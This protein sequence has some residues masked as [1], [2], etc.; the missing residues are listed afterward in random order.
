M[1]TL[2]KDIFKADMS[3]DS[4]NRTDVFDMFWNGRG[5][6]SSSQPTRNT[7]SRRRPLNFVADPVT[8]T[9]LVQGADAS[10]LAEIEDL[11]ERYDRAE[12][13]NSESVRRTTRVSLRYAKAKDVADV[14]KDVYRDLLSPNDK[15][16]VATQ[17]PQ[18]PGRDQ[19]SGANNDFY[20]AMFSYL[21]DDPTKS[22]IVPRFKGMLSV[23][24]DERANGVVISAPQIILTEVL[25]MVKDLDA[26]ARPMRP[27]VRLLRVQ[28]Q[29]TA[30]Q[31]QQAVRSQKAATASA[32][33]P[34]ATPVSGANGN[35]GVEPIL[36]GNRLR[37]AR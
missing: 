6:S 32:T 25:K 11:I 31:V 10:Q 18:Q 9:V 17:Q 37:G 35:G 27:V 14:I 20:S 1:V 28:N 5:S 30:T 36:G 24:I 26:D 29:G 23:G 8:N 16:L 33:S 7:L 15:A 13:P 3:K 2:L 19:R 4:S 12:P 34:S 21:T 22:E